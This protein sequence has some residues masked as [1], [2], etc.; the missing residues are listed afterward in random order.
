MSKQNPR[1]K[2]TKHHRKP[3]SIGGTNEDRNISYV[4]E[5]QHR[6]WH[7]VVSNHTAQ[8]ICH[9]LNEKYIDPDFRF[10]CISADKFDEAIKLLKQLT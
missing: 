5:G 3:T 9:I 4:P 10:I 7:D 8:T 2:L 1:H 6:S